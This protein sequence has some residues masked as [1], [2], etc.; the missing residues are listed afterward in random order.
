MRDL[1]GRFP[2]LK[3][4]VEAEEAA[5]RKKKEENERK[6]AKK[7]HPWTQSSSERQNSR[8]QDKN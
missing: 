7:T 4:K 2:G 8:K 1:D 6:R 3:E 5:D